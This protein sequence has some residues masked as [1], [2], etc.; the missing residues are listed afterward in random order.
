MRVLQLKIFGTS[1]YIK[2]GYQ[3]KST[4]NNVIVIKNYN[5]KNLYRQI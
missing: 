4:I 1:R 5:N 2:L 3:F